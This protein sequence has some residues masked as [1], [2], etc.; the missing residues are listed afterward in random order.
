MI[1]KVRN[2]SFPFLNFQYKMNIQVYGASNKKLA[3]VRIQMF[4]TDSYEYVF[5]QYI[6]NSLQVF[7]GY[8]VVMRR[9][10]GSH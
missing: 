1:M 7:I 5:L 8:R 9:L 10:I 3:L 4:V 2:K 6:L